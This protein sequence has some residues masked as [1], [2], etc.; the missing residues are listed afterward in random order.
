MVYEPQR[1]ANGE[2]H[3]R[4]TSVSVV[5]DSVRPAASAPWAGDH[6]GNSLSITVPGTPAFC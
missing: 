4:Q 6:T 5:V 2:Q 3:S 1:G